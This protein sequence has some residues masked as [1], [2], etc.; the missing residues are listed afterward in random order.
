[1]KSKSN[2][3][4]ATRPPS[5]IN[6]KVNPAYTRWYSAKTDQAGKARER[7]KNNPEQYEKTRNRWQAARKKKEHEEMGRIESGH[8]KCLECG[9]VVTKETATAE[10][11]RTYARSGGARGVCNSCD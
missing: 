8:V 9:R 11:W 4:N 6:G 3:E 1:M 7:R 10:L 2:A 5:R